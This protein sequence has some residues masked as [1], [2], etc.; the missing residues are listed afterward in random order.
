MGVSTRLRPH[1]PE[2][3]L[4]SN[5]WLS[6][7]RI[8]PSPHFSE[9]A[10]GSEIDLIVLHCVSLPAG[11]DDVHSIHALFQGRLDTSAH[12]SFADLEGVRVSAHLLIDRA[13]EVY[14]YV[15]FDKAAWHAG[16]SSWRGRRHCNDFSIGI[17]LQGSDETAF[18]AIQYTRLGDVLKVLMSSYSHLGLQSIVG[19]CHV[20]PGRKTDPGPKFDWKRLMRTLT[21]AH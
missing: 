11:S 3:E 21:E 5:V 18:E 1:L 16:E 10:D 14:Q 19:H 12:A 13:G 2:T 4:E 8:M 17:E 9:R 6:D 7:V 15:P 20:A